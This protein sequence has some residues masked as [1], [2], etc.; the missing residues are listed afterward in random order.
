MRRYFG[1]PLPLNVHSSPLYVTDELWFQAF[2]RTL[3]TDCKAYPICRLSKDE[4]ENDGVMFEALLG[5]EKPEGNEGGSDEGG[6]DQDRGVIGYSS[7]E[8]KATKNTVT[9]FWGVFRMI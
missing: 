9:T 6:K 2:W 5:H 1:S 8:K 3:V 4:I 7:R